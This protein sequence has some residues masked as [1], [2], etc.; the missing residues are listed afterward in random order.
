ML[1]SVAGC[2]LAWGSCDKEKQAEPA[3]QTSLSPVC[4]KTS[5]NRIDAR[6]PETMV[7]DWEQPV[8]LGAPVNTLCPQDA[9]EIA[10]DGSFLYVMYTEDVLENMTPEQTLARYNNTYRLK[11]IGGPDEFG[12]PEF[13]DLGKGASQS[14][15]GELSFSPDGRAVYF[16]SLRASNQGY[17]QNPP[18]DDFLDIYVADIVD[19]APGPGRNLGPPVNSVYPD[20]EHAMHP[21]GVTLYFASRRPGGAGGADIWT[22]AFEGGTWSDTANLGWPINTLADDYQPTFTADGD[23]MYYASGR[24]PIIGMAIY[25]S[26]RD[27]SAWGDPE[28]VIRGLAGEPALT[29]DGRLL[30]F[31]HVLSDALGTYDADVWLCRR[32]AE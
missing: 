23:T 26:V 3:P 31:V 10:P 11:R 9:I 30:Y 12:E 15:N 17:L 2:L 29:A 32:A 24:N 18:T 1:V 22:S 21:D 25:R 28:L 5:T 19:G 20:G 4:R 13:Y 6:T 7:P 27:G 14:F 16:H 8:R